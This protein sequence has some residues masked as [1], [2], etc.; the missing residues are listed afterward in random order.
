M[1]QHF[2]EPVFEPVPAPVAPA[3]LELFGVA[4]CERPLGHVDTAIALLE[5]A[6]RLRVAD[7]PRSLPVAET[8]NNLAAAVSQQ[9]DLETAAMLL[10]D[11]HAI[12]AEILGPHHTLSVQSV[13]NRAVVAARLGRLDDAHA[14]LA[15]AEA[16]YR[17]LK[18]SGQSG[19]AA[20]LHNRGYLLARAGR[21]EDA[22]VALEE[23]L[24]IREANLP[25][26]HPELRT[27]LGELLE[28]ARRAGRG[29]EVAR[30]EARLEGGVV[31]DPDRSR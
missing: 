28:I 24:A 25:A 15:E 22:R 26:D 17:A 7:A 13:A 23:A 12:R 8:L 3:R 30:L 29:E 31:P 1:A 19:L 2:V 27:T 21:D 4:A 6:L 11:S 5:E 18:T 16:G 20:V 9:G 14:L 10:H